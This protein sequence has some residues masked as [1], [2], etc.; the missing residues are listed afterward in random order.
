MTGFVFEATTITNVLKQRPSDMAGF[1]STHILSHKVP[2]YTPNHP[3]SVS[4]LVP[5]LS[6]YANNH[7]YVTELYNVVFCALYEEKKHKRSKDGQY[8]EDIY[9]D[10]EAKKEVLYRT[11]QS[12]DRMYEAASRIM[13]G[14]GAPDPRSGRH[15]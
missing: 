9:T 1:I 10:L 14:I 13:T 7:A 12:L 5:L 3:L 6:L 8:D 2:S 4:E 15:P 11:A